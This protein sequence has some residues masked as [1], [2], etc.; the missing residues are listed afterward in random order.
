M[1]YIESDPV[2]EATHFLGGYLRSCRLVCKTKLKETGSFIKRLALIQDCLKMAPVLQFEELLVEPLA[3]EPHYCFEISVP[4]LRGNSD[5]L[6][7]PL[8]PTTCNHRGASDL[9]EVEF[10]MD[11]DYIFAVFEATNVRFHPN[12]SQQQVLTALALETLK[13]HTGWVEKEV[14]AHNAEVRLFFKYQAQGL[15]I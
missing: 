5:L 10:R 2:T 6:T 7:Y 15:G 14:D 9:T 8:D 3:E 4:V 1:A 12:D 11:R 13:T